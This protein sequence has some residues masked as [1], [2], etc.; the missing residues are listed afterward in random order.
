MPKNIL[1]RILDDSITLMPRER[2]NR[3]HNIIFFSE[4]TINQDTMHECCPD[5]VATSKEKRKL[6]REM[7]VVEIDREIAVYKS[8]WWLEAIY[9]RR[10]IRLFRERE[11]ILKL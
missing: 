10:I 7:T 11:T 6:A 4:L 5:T 3:F 9:S 2:F 8:T 1:H